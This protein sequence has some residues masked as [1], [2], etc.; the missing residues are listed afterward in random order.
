VLKP[1]GIDGVFIDTPCR[2]AVILGLVSA[3]HAACLGIRQ[4]F[5]RAVDHVQID[6]KLG[7]VQRQ[8]LEHVGGERGNAAFARRKSADQRQAAGRRAPSGIRAEEI[9]H[10]PCN[11]V[12]RRKEVERSRVIWLARPEYVCSMNQTMQTG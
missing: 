6:R 3:D 2:N 5:G 4:R 11:R 12:A 7:M 1:Y 9:K 8:L 10:G